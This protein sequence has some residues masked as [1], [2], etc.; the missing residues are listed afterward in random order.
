[1]NARNG[2]MY[3]FKYLHT[4]RY[5]IYICEKWQRKP[6]SRQIT[7]QKFKTNLVHTYTVYCRWC[8]RCIIFKHFNCKH[9]EL[10]FIRTAFGFGI[11][12]TLVCCFVLNERFSV[13]FFAMKSHNRT[14]VFQPINCVF[15]LAQNNITFALGVS[16]MR[17]NYPIASHSFNSFK[18][19]FLLLAFLI[20]YCHTIHTVFLSF[21][22]CKMCVAAF[23]LLQLH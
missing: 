6:S 18:L 19:Q 2:Y 23:S 10:D 12:F 3:T 22:N 1:M 14:L 9:E 4:L 15:R 7:K 21:F 13:L 20:Y 11:H 8:C 16:V 17:I 5:N